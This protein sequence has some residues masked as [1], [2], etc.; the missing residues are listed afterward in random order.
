MSLGRRLAKQI[1]GDDLLIRV[2]SDVAQGLIN[3]D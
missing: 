1:T 3:L 2:K